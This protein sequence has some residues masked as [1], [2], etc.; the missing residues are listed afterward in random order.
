LNYILFSASFCG[1][2]LLYDG[3]AGSFRS[4]RLR[5]RQ[6]KCAV[7]SDNPTI[8]ALQDYELFCGSKATDKVGGFLLPALC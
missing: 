3:Y 1:K 7:C 2:L 5:G 4:I 6:E 8:T